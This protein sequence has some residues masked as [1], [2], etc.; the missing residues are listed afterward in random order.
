[1]KLSK[2]LI[3]MLS[4]GVIATSC[5]RHKPT[6]SNTSGVTSI[7]C[8]ESFSNIIDQ[9]IDVF[10]FTYPQASIVPYYINESDAIDSL[11]NGATNFIVVTRELDPDM[12]TNLNNRDRRVK[13]QKIAVDAIAVI[14]N[15]DNPIEELSIS[16]L[17]DIL[18]GKVT[19]WDEISPNHLKDIMLVFDNQ[20][21]ST[22]RYM[23]DSITGGADFA[24]N[25]FAQKTNKEVFEVVKKK[26]NAIGV[27]GVTWLN[28][29]LDGTSSDEQ[30]IKQ[31]VDNLNRNDTTELKSEYTANMIKDL[32][33]L[34][35][36]RDDNPV[37][38][39]PFQYYIYTGD[40]PLFRSVYAISTAPAGSLSHG[41]F[42]FLTGVISQ[43]IILG[44]GILPANIPLRNVELQ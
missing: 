20:G 10:E 38:Y 12:V 23:K 18:T 36:R 43:K 30:T 39:K 44:T 16:E 22:V 29:D 17:R 37:A 13:S 6:D 7:M 27:I 32:K 35:I 21:S 11:Y 40:Y 24:K 41:F 3:M 19:N 33:V 15:N 14:A 42:T 5:S 1:M 25:V 9:E 2:F 31:R 26:K 8:D 4:A 34:A 28:S